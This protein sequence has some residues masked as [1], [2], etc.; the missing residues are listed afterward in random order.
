MFARMRR[1]CFL[2]AGSLIPATFAADCTRTSTGMVPLNDPYFFSYRG[3]AG[4]LYPNG[5]NHR[6]TQHEA[7]GL[8]LAAEVRP[9]NTLGA[10]DE[11]GGKIVFLSTGMSNTTQEFSAF[12][13]IADK[14][15][16]KNPKLVI[17]DGAQGGAT[18]SAIVQNGA[19]YW[20]EVDR[21]LA[22]AGVTAAQ[23][24][25]GWLKEALAGPNLPFPQDAQ[26]LLRWLKP[27]VQIL[28]SRFP[29]LRLLYLSS[30]IYGGY[31]TTALNPEPYAYQSGFAVKWLIEGQLTGEGDLSHDAGKAPW[32]AWGPY[33]WADGTRE[34]D[35]G[36]TWAC[37]DL[38][39]SDGTH[40]ADSGRQKV[41][42]LLLDFLKSDSTARPWFVRPGPTPPA[43]KPAAVVNS[44]NYAPE[45]AARTIASI[46]GSELAGVVASPQGVPLPTV[47]GGTVVRIDDQPALLY[48]AS[49]TQINF[50]VP[51]DAGGKNLVVAR[52]GAISASL[53][54]SP[55][56]YAPAIFTLDGLP[57]GPA[58]ARHAVLAGMPTV[59]VQSPALPGEWI[60][61]YLTG[62]GSRNPAILAPE[63]L[64]AVYVGAVS[65]EVNYYG[66]APG[67]PG[68]NQINF[69][70]P[71]QLGP[72]QY[73]LSVGVGTIFGNTAMLAIAASNSPPGSAATTTAATTTDGA[74]AC[75]LPTQT[76][77][78]AGR[79]ILNSAPEASSRLAAVMVPPL[80]R[81]M[82]STMW[83]PTPAPL[84][85]AEVGLNR[86]GNASWGMPGPLSATVTTTRPSSRQPWISTMPPCF[87]ASPAFTSSLSSTLSQQLVAPGR[88]RPPSISR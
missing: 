33:L 36:L 20:A 28:R 82:L 12:K 30:R 35:D 5:T 75:S 53:P 63:I 27:L 7:A 65:A 85:L 52:D 32:L 21:R 46:Y 41:A 83:S 60:A 86:C 67:F 87:I 37:A 43:P 1:L 81:T 8:R 49:P 54:L 15:P 76:R 72:G 14:D 68:L 79:L 45:I 9:R 23:V 59:T 57:G 13:Q 24:Q 44:A 69:R 47:L 34:R 84:F 16:E 22:A 74:D 51:K 29:N 73:P 18:A 71:A 10:V 48:Y 19:N 61:L 78:Y 26:D 88:R 77:S 25:A 42:G 80:R 11:A 70:V 39:P 62:L 38:Q 40:P 56:M 17:V 58:A 6:P 66:A 4:G 50:V 55:V 3:Y 2:L 64:P 31:A